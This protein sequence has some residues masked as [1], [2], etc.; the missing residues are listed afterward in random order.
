MPGTNNQTAFLLEDKAYGKDR[1]DWPDLLFQLLPEPNEATKRPIGILMD[2]DRV[3]IDPDNHEIRDFPEL[4]KVLSSEMN[5]QDIEYYLR[6]NMQFGNGEMGYIDLRG[7]YSCSRASFANNDTSTARMPSTF[8]K[9]KKAKV[10]DAPKPNALSMRASRFRWS[11]PCLAWTIRDAS[12]RLEDYVLSVLPPE[13]ILENST[14]AFGRSFT[15]AEQAE[16]KEA[17]K[18]KFGNR[19]RKHKRVAE[20]EAEEVEVVD[21]DD[22]EFE[23]DG[24]EDYLDSLFS[25][26]EIDEA[27]D[28]DS[29]SAGPL[30]KRKSSLS[31]DSDDGDAYRI[32]KRR[33]TK[34]TSIEFE[35]AGF[36]NVK[37][38]LG[39]VDIEAEKKIFDP[40]IGNKRGRGQSSPESEGED[41]SHHVSKRG[42]RDVD[43]RRKGNA[44]TQKA[45]PKAKR[46]GVDTKNLNR[47]P[48]K[49]RKR[50]GGHHLPVYEQNS[51]RT[52]S[53]AT[54]RGPNRAVYVS[55]SPDGAE[56]N[57]DP[58]GLSYLD[59]DE[60]ALL[61]EQSRNQQDKFQHP[62]SS[63]KNR[64]AKRKRTTS[65]QED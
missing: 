21:P 60:E 17:S 22:E 50:V 31:L 57:A 59:D 19:R 16:A 65:P 27:G 58:L 54:N 38:T 24:E 13:C 1:D 49:D 37:R 3:V 7:I 10:Y 48:R 8:V 28:G 23:T 42:R 5:G 64:V 26:G 55:T 53:G 43:E 12:D 33:D 51:S 35:D 14:E 46:Q 29:I 6:K 30:R 47:W 39:I 56:A 45:G 61:A 18:G 9:G 40:T 63:T 2:R 36:P 44:D 25:D 62:A 20:A 32:I 34:A 15:K 11:A 4:P 52:Q 41:L